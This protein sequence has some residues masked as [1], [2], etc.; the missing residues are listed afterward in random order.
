WE[1]HDN[2]GN[3]PGAHHRQRRCYRDARRGRS[4]GQGRTR[5]GRDDRR[6]TC[7]QE[8]VDMPT[9]LPQTRRRIAIADDKP[10]YLTQ[11]SQVVRM[12][13]Y[14]PVPLGGKYHAV[15]ELLAEL[16][17]V[18]AEGLVCDHKLSEGNYALFQGAE[19][20]AA[21]YGSATPALLVTDYVESD[22]Q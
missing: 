8:T 13:G 11:K 20:V 1:N 21:L 17:T 3:G 15:G 16:Q 7:A 10:D 4:S 9:T 2:R 5:R 14:E 19:V 22:L 6:T 12:A 18:K